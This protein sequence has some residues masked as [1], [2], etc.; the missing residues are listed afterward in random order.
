MLNFIT[1]WLIH[2]D[3]SHLTSVTVVS[4]LIRDFFVMSK[5]ESSKEDGGF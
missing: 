1:T 4:V 2:M 3:F 5:N